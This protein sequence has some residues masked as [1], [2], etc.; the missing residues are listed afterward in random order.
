MS[1]P[2][3]LVLLLCIS[4]F[5]LRADV[6]SNALVRRLCVVEELEVVVSAKLQLCARRR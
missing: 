3:Q 1:Q 4:C 6:F 5:A 2:Q